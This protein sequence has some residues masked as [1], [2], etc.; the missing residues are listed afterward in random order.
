MNVNCPIAETATIRAPVVKPSDRW[1]GE[2]EDD[3]KDNWDDEDEEEQSD[4]TP[5]VASQPK[6]KKNLTQIIAEKE[7]KKKR[8]AEERRLKVSTL[9]SD[10]ERISAK[11]FFGAAYL[12]QENLICF[13]L[14]TEN[15]QDTDFHMNYYYY[16]TGRAGIKECIARRTKSREAPPATNAGRIGSSNRNGN[17]WNLHRW[18]D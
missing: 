1:E 15:H 18:D 9:A 16:R 12:S 13:I 5:V 14:I 3:V 6:K 11:F 8:E 17:M 7:E 4:S 2:D 10:L